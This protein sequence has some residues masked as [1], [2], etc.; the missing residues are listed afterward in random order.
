MHSIFASWLIAKEGAMDSDQPK[1]T[2]VAVEAMPIA[3]TLLAAS[4]ARPKKPKVPT[5]DQDPDPEYGAVLLQRS[6]T[7]SAEAVKWRQTFL[8]TVAAANGAA[9]IAVGSIA[10]RKDL[11][12]GD[13][14]T[15]F[16]AVGIFIGGLMVSGVAMY[17]E[18]ERCDLTAKIDEDRYFVRSKKYG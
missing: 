11:A 18:E 4:A 15:L 9:A 5:P 17:A 1:S 16:L 13:P 14:Y 7:A 3:A 6:E 10:L 8:T 12:F 2:A